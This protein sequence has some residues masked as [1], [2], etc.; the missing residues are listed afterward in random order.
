M[1]QRNKGRYAAFS[2][3]E[4]IKHSRFVCGMSRTQNLL[5]LTNL[6][7]FCL[8]SWVSLWGPRIVVRSFWSPLKTQGMGQNRYPQNSLPWSMETRTASPTAFLVTQQLDNR[9]RPAAYFHPTCWCL[10]GNE[11][12]NPPPVGW[13]LGVIPL[14]IPLKETTS[15]TRCWGSFLPRKVVEA[16]I[17][18][19]CE[20]PTAPQAPAGTS[21]SPGRWPACGPSGPQIQPIHR[22]V[23]TRR[24]ICR[25]GTPKK[26]GSVGCPFGFPKTPLCGVCFR[27]TPRKNAAV[28]GVRLV[29]FPYNQP[30][31]WFPKTRHTWG[32]KEPNKLKPAV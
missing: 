29:S 3:L 24:W 16:H 13:L 8:L 25:R 30:K 9:T 6:P 4:A 2:E 10:V 31:G 18:A 21:E 27:G 23:W 5:G 26:S 19:A 15:W 12:M 32:A 14:G 22:P 7:G 17:S 1:S 20:A 11:G 28:W